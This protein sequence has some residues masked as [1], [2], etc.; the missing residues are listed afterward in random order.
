MIGDKEIPT[1]RTTPESYGLHELF[2]QMYNEGCKYVVMEVSSHSLSLDRVYGI[3]YDTAVFTN[4]TRDHLDFH[5][6]M[7]AYAE[8]KSILFEH[9]ESA[10]IN[11]DDK[12]S[13]YMLNKA[14]GKILTVS[15]SDDSAE[16][17]AKR[18]K[19][20]SEG[21]EFSVLTTGMLKPVQLAIP[22]KF[23]VYNAMSAIGACLNLG[24]DLKDITEAMLKC[25]G[26]KGR[27]EVV[28]TGKDFS[29][30]IDYAHTP[31]GLE[32]IISTMKGI[33]K[34]RVITL[35]GCGGDRDRTKRP[36]MGEVAARESDF[37]IV[38]SDNPRTEEPSAIIDDILVGLVD[39]KTPYTVI[40]NRREAIKWG[41]ENAQ[42]DDILLLAGKGHETYQVLG[43]EKIHFDEREV[44]RDCLN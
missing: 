25:K 39:T 8:A 5:K 7:E 38:T 35:F 13:S 21:V 19:Y 3:T 15:I 34:G 28:P 36:I 27:A 16:V 2:Y 29:V 33:C 20:H 12:Y 30:I 10:V 4:L 6:T 44:V 37:V 14:S 17:T 43:K 11:I 23:S 26:I 9:A 42:K 40:E 22:G 24:F 41:L 32:N 31:D 1:E 18:I